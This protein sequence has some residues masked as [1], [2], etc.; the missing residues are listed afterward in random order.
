MSLPPF[1]GPRLK[2]ERA[3]SHANDLYREIQAFLA[4]DPYHFVLERH[5]NRSQETKPC[6]VFRAR[7][8]IPI[9]WLAMIGDAVHNLRAALDLMICDIVALHG[10]SRDDARFPFG[11]NVEKF[12]S[13]LKGKIQK[14]TP[15]IGSDI[16]DMIRALK[17]YTGGNAD[18]R[19]LHD[20][21][22]IDKHRLPI[23]AT[24]VTALPDIH[25]GGF[26]MESNWVLGLHDGDVALWLPEEATLNIES[27]VPAPIDILFEGKPF[28][29][30]PVI[31]TLGKLGQ[32]VEGIVQT[33]KA[34]C[35][36]QQ[37]AGP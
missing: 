4:R 35:L 21:D 20:L 12:E 1:V 23:L 6:F 11:S 5:P 36:G 2:V 15:Q 30:R 25:T 32:L 18:L 24:V 13:V 3:K 22:I 31:A 34:H 33:F 10:G 16:L 27:D 7:E 14:P 37:K 19:G 28:H 17:P 29:A 9:M 26:R 8:K